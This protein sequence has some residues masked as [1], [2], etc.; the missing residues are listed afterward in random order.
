MA[1]WR[2]GAP[3]RHAPRS[4]LIEGTQEDECANARN[5]IVRSR[6]VGV[7]HVQ[8][9]THCN[10]LCNTPDLDEELQYCESCVSSTSASGKKKMRMHGI[11]KDCSTLQHTLQHA[12]Q[13]A[14]YACG[15]AVLRDIASLSCMR[16]ALRTPHKNCG[17]LQHTLQ[18]TGCAVRLVTCVLHARVH[19]LCHPPRFFDVHTIIQTHLYNG[20]LGQYTRC[21]HSKPPN[22]PP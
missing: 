15:V 16:A 3:L 11:H 4:L 13:H 8:T 2:R 21:E 19:S 12:L 17:T 7:R 20:L 22:P 1:R 5:L 18:R 9:A 10:T 6:C 14:G